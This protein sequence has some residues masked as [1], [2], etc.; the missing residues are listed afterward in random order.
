VSSSVRSFSQEHERFKRIG[1]GEFL[2]QK[3]ALAIPVNRMA[4]LLSAV[5]LLS[6]FPASSQVQQAA[7]RKDAA[8]CQL[9]SAVVTA[10]GYATP[11]QI[12]TDIAGTFT[13]AST[14]ESDPI[15]ILT[16]GNAM[17]RVEIAASAGTSVRV[18]NGGLGRFHASGGETKDL[19]TANTFHERVPTNP[20]LSLLAECGS[21]NVQAID[22]GT[23]TVDGVA[24]H[25]VDLAWTSHPTAI[26]SMVAQDEL[27]LSET[28][29][30]IDPQ[31]NTVVEMDDDHFA[32]NDSTVPFHYRTVYSGYKA[33]NGHMV[34]HTISTYINSRLFD[35]IVVLAYD[36]PGQLDPQQFKLGGLQ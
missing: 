5:G 21:P 4:L 35:T 20:T 13:L 23:I 33:E 7:L 28:H 1:V 17:T 34:P 3:L 2:T 27:R 9:A 22:G 26:N 16:I 19:S 25:R 29:F 11:L 15:R 10:S 18:V 30:L 6:T 24:L 12:N 32:E 36:E 8:A 14:G 31:R